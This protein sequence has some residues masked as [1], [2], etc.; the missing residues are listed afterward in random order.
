MPVNEIAYYIYI[1]DLHD[2]YLAFQRVFQ[3]SESDVRSRT[4]HWNN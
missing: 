3:T 2:I 1:M 4:P